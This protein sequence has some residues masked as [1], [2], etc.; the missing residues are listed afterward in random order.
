MRLVGENQL[1]SG[2]LRD[3][4]GTGD[5]NHWYR[6]SSCYVAMESPVYGIC[7]CGMQRHFNLEKRIWCCDDLNR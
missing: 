4:S 6:D 3:E 5:D 7:R 2:G 1:D